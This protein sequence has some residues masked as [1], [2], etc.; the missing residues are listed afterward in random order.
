MLKDMSNTLLINGILENKGFQKKGEIDSLVKILA[1]S[2]ILPKID[3]INIVA[4]ETEPD[5]FKIIPGRSIT[6]GTTFLKNPTISLLCLRYGI[7][8]QIWFNASGRKSEC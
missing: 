3:Q 7:E 2:S 6:I 4:S 8:W 5:I 1:R